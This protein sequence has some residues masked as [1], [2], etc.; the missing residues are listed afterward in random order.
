MILRG[1]VGG[2]GGV[3]VTPTNLTLA[4]RRALPQKSPLRLQRAFLLMKLGNAVR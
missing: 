1:S 2:S 4:R 3:G